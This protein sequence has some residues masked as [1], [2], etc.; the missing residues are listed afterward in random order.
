MP[1]TIF[2]LLKLHEHCDCLLVRTP[3]GVALRT[4]QDAERYVREGADHGE[5]GCRSW[6]EVKLYDSLDE[7]FPPRPS[8]EELEAR[9]EAQREE[10][11][12][13]QAQHP[14]VLP[15]PPKGTD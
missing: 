9:R 6:V 10:E 11:A 14:P 5:A 8:E 3:T 1:Q 4:R 12:R 7:A 15:T 2:V 13:L